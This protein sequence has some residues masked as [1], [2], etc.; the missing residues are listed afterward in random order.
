M[1][2]EAATFHADIL[3]RT[4][5]YPAAAT[6]AAWGGAALAWRRAARLPA[7]AATLAL[8]AGFWAG[9]VALRAPFGQW[10]PVDSID[11]LAYVVPAAAL[12][13]IVAD[14]PRERLGRP[15]RAT[16]GAAAAAFTALLVA[17][18]LLAG[19]ASRPG[20]PWP[21]WLGGAAGIAVVW[22]AT[23]HAADR[24][25]RPSGWYAAWA[26]AALGASG[27]FAVADSAFVGQLLGAFAVV[28]G[29]LALGTLRWPRLAPAPGAATVLAAAWGGVLLYGLAWTDTPRGPVL[30]AAAAPAVAA[31]AAQRIRGRFRAL[32][33]GGLCALVLAGAAAGWSYRASTAAAAPADQP[34]EDDYGYD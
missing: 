3:L 16:L 31:L 33:A 29:L 32:L 23:A 8:A 28:T 27:V 4:V 5:V 18:T 15:A 11:W 24:E 9:L 30:L 1:L 26:G 12:L 20:S 14:L 21:A 17:R 25:P 10:P 34:S 13:G 2:N 6:A 22:A 7:A 19:L